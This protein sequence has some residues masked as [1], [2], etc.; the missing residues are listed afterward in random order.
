MI[1]ACR[2]AKRY[3]AKKLQALANKLDAKTA[4]YK[5]L[6]DTEPTVD[7][8]FYCI[9]TDME[10]L[11]DDFYYLINE[12]KK[13]KL[14]INFFRCKCNVEILSQKRTLEY[15]ALTN[16]HTDYDNIDF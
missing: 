7:Y 9:K 2:T 4:K 6:A 14:N 10:R 12:I 11:N 16:S 8:S 1:Q 13:L 15:N 3:D 5:K